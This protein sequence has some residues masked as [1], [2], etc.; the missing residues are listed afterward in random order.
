[1]KTKFTFKTILSIIICFLICRF[2]IKAQEKTTQQQEQNIVIPVQM[3]PQNEIFISGSA[4][5][6]NG[7]A[8]I[9]YEEVFLKLLPE[10]NK[11]KIIVTPEGSWSA[12]YIVKS[13]NKGFAVK[14]ESGD[15]NA[16]FN[17]IVTGEK[18]KPVKGM[19]P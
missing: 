14:S 16:H 10:S 3:H 13:D 9:K 18:R 1:M 2:E 19:T 11:I 5:L 7:T 6:V 4:K 15:L 8:E 17:W 12:I